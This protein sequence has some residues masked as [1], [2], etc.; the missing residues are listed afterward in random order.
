[1]FDHE[2]MMMM[3]EMRSTGKRG[4]LAGADGF[5]V[6]PVRAVGTSKDQIQMI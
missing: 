3:G 1:M 4:F 2:L 5:S 6:K